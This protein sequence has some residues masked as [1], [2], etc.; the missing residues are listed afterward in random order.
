[1]KTIPPSHQLRRPRGL[2]SCP[3]RPAAIAPPDRG[4]A[5]MATLK[6]LPD[7]PVASECPKSSMPTS[8]TKPD[9]E[10]VQHLCT[11]YNI[12]LWLW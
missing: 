5:G 12:S 8:A 2:A 10:C 4:R 6:R 11:S 1:M 9:Q 3:D 7:L